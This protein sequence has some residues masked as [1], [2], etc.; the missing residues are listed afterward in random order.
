[1]LYYA[2]SGQSESSALFVTSLDSKET[3]RLVA[4]TSNAVYAPPG[5][6]L[7]ERGGKLVAQRFDAKTLEL[8]GDAV[9]VAEDVAYDAGAWRSL[10]A[11]SEDGVL[12][13]QTILGF[14]NQVAWFDRD[15]KRVGILPSSENSYNLA[16]SPDDTR[17]AVSRA[18]FEGR[19]RDIWIYD[20]LRQGNSRLTFDPG[21]EVNPI[22]SPDGSR[23]VFEFD[24]EGVFDIYQKP[25]TGSTGEELLLQTGLTKFATDWSPDGRFIIYDSVDAK[26]NSDLWALAM[27]DEREPV[28]FLG[29]DAEER[30][31]RF[32]PDGRWLAYSSDESGRSEVFVQTFPASGGKWQVSN[33]GGV[34]PRWR[35]DG[36]EL[37]YLSL[38][39]KLM[40]VTVRPDAN[41][42]HD[43]PRE[44]F[45]S[46]AIDLFTY[47]SPYA[48][49]ADGERFYFN[50]RAP[51]AASTPIRL[52]L[53][54]TAGLKR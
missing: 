23:I 27:T 37:F 24:R 43:P 44:L 49:T 7:F 21:A 46:R 25:A 42:E 33:G 39:Q 40:A 34:V 28:L 5:Y 15:G 36:R 4:T 10:F 30:E 45:E 16:L 12:A 41:F 38:D 26:S 1:L 54:W 6:L 29:T 17:L 3:R 8:T 53:N 9:V 35:R 50:I 2:R 32:S 47:R 19:G 48:V 11:V 14:T 18:S 20:L 31:A 22:W 52:V 13:Y 51:D